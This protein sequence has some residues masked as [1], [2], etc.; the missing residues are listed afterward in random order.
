V[1]YAWALQVGGGGSAAVAD[2]RTVAVL[3]LAFVGI[4]VLVEVSR[5]LN[6]WRAGLALAMIAGVTLVME[7]PFARTFFALPTSPGGAGIVVAI[8]TAASVVAIEVGL[9]LVGWRPGPAKEAD[10]T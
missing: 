3:T 8:A 9:R 10:A 4:W 1:A 2:A 7:V 5:P 6:L